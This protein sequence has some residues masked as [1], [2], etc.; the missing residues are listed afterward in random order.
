MGSAE[1]GPERDR[2]AGVGEE[3][4][5]R[6]PSA[7]C[8]SG[9]AGCGRTL[10]ES[11][12]GGTSEAC[13]REPFGRQFAADNATLRGFAVS[14][15]SNSVLAGAFEG[16][17]TF[18]A[19]S[20]TSAGGTD[21][22][23]AKLDACGVPLW[24]ARFGDAEAQAALDVAADDKGALVLGEFTGA[25]DFGTVR[26]TASPPGGPE[27]F[28]A[29]LKASGRTRWAAQIA[30]DEDSILL[31]KAIASDGRG[32]ALVLGTLEGAARVAGHRIE[33]RAIGTFVV[34]LDR[35]GRF[36]WVSLPPSGS[37]T[38]EIGIEVDDDDNIFIASA[39]GRGNA[40]FLT[41]LD[42]D[43]A[44]LWH[45]RFPGSPEQAEDLYDFAV[46]PDGS[47]LLAGTGVFG[48]EELPGGPSPFVAKIDP[49]G[50]VLWVTRF[51]GVQTAREIAASD[52]AVF[53]AG[54]SLCTP[55]ESPSCSA[56]AAELSPD[57]QVR[58]T[59]RLGQGAVVSGLEVDARD[60]PMLAGSFQGTVE[61]GDDVL[62]SE[63]NALFVGRLLASD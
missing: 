18:G 38:G 26:L 22:F 16:T 42:E 56:W 43:G 9:A 55:D 39:D 30:A 51:D 25:V 29:N 37:D 15:D 35:S 23:V 34:R 20:L 33:R 27:L 19:T 14:D 48:E 47:V 5:L 3:A 45:K 2:G 10:A 58:W 6:S 60:N 54:D 1:G 11:R 7:A 41:K 8:A 53:L 24:S 21:V 59:E 63:E 13:G 50:N 36:S 61:V 31:G 49:D 46:D 17:L 44:L 4:E 40:T 62:T 28:V 12:A 52:D 32:G 57:G